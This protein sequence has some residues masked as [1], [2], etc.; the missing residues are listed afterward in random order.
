[1]FVIYYQNFI[2]IFI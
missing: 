2:V 1:M